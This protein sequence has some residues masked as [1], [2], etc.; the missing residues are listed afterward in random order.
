MY[1]IVIH[2]PKARINSVLH[3]GTL[4]ECKDILERLQ[5]NNGTSANVRSIVS[6]AEVPTLGFHCT[7]PDRYCERE[8]LN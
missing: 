7:C 6:V 1:A 2:S 5:R 4:Q 3:E 8:D